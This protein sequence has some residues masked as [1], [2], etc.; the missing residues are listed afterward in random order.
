MKLWSN[1]FN[2]SGLSFNRQSIF[3]SL[4]NSLL[5]SGDVEEV[6]P[7]KRT[8]LFNLMDSF[9]IATAIISSTTTSVVPIINDTLETF[10]NYVT[11]P[12]TNIPIV[13]NIYHREHVTQRNLIPKYSYQAPVE[14]FYKQL[15][16]IG[17][18][19]LLIGAII[20]ICLLSFLLFLII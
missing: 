6:Y 4:S 9:Y 1:N 19:G 17:V 3:D 12:I 8:G 10:T 20:S 7:E 14:W 11:I 15:K 18:R 16:Y 5:L 2:V 13:D